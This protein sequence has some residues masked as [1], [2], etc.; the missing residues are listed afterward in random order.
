MPVDF[1]ASIARVIAPYRDSEAIR[2]SSSANCQLNEFLQII[3]NIIANKANSIVV[4]NDSGVILDKHIRTVSIAVFNK[5]ADD[6]VIYGE[7]AIAKFSK[8]KD[9]KKRYSE[10][11]GISFA[12]AALERIIKHNAGNHE[13]RTVGKDKTITKKWLPIRVSEKASIFLAAVLDFV[14]KRIIKNAISIVLREKHKTISVA[15]INKA[16]REDE[17]IWHMTWQYRIILL[18][19][20]ARGRGTTTT[21][22]TTATTA[23]SKTKRRNKPGKVAARETKKIIK[24]NKLVG[25]LKPVFA[26]AKLEVLDKYPNEKGLSMKMT[27]NAKL[28]I[29]QYAEKMTLFVARHAAAFVD[30]CKQ[31]TI[32]T[33]VL[34]RAIDST[35][36]D[37]F[38]YYR[39]KFARETGVKLLRVAGI[40]RVSKDVPDLILEIYGGYIVQIAEIAAEITDAIGKHT[41]DNDAVQEAASILGVHITSCIEKRGGIKR[42]KELAKERRGVPRVVKK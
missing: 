30:N 37:T 35:V 28:T 17:P 27:D 40:S 24:S 6:V 7:S 19:K 14:T 12:P 29:Q 41:I 11:A 32:Y 36:P 4:M 26:L 31:S 39:G 5:L 10:R 18:D 38:N 34:D 9:I 25:P 33:K 20:V 2:V 3:A 1:S 15:A 16:L 42:R 13:T 21:A 23:E 8:S 22:T